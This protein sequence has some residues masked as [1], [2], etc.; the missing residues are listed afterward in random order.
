PFLWAELGFAAGM[1]LFLTEFCAFLTIGL[2]EWLRIGPFIGY[3]LMIATI[4][5]L[6]LVC[7]ISFLRLPGSATLVAGFAFLLR[8][9]MQYG[10]P[11][12]V[13]LQ[14]GALGLP[15]RVN[16]LQFSISAFSIPPGVLLV[17]LIIDLV[18][19]ARPS[20]RTVPAL[21][22]VAA[23]VALT[24]NHLADPRWLHLVAAAGARLGPEGVDRYLAA[25]APAQWPTLLA[26]PLLAALAARAGWHLGIQFRYTTR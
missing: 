25:V 4:L 17:G 11:P 6:C 7:A 1:G 9:L 22:V 23:A 5:P 8:L 26:V 3:G 24:L 21:A 12:A 2:T 13:A 18:I 10:I 14:A 15:Y 16:A 19:S 20:P